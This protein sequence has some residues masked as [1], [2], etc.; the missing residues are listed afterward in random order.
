MPHEREKNM[1]FLIYSAI[2]LVL[3]FL[4]GVYLVATSCRFGTETLFDDLLMI[5]LATI[6]GPIGIIITIIEL[7]IEP[8]V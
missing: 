2:W 6:F 4:H 5:A 8:R 1:N 7:I 3:G